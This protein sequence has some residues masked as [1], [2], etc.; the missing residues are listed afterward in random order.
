MCL[1]TTSSANTILDAI[2]KISLPSFSKAD[3]RFENH[4]ANF[5]G[6]GKLD[7]DGTISPTLLISTTEI[8]ENRLCNLYFFGIIKESHI[9]TD[10][11]QGQTPCNG[12]SGGALVING[13]QVY[14][15]NKYP[16][17]V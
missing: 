1:L 9:C 10:G 14:Y 4:Y 5:T 3:D 8:I 12:D 7:D 11:Y 2:Q 15:T 13:V 17:A 16:F 6:W